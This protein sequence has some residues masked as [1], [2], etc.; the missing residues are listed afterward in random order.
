MFFLIYANSRLQ[1]SEVQ[2]DVQA[3][4]TITEE[5]MVSHAMRESSSANTPEIIDLST[6]DLLVCVIA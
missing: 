1:G 2:N 3:D 6:S 4:V 5:A